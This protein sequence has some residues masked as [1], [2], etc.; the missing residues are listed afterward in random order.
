MTTKQQLPLST[1][2]SVT[3]GEGS[4]SLKEVSKIAQSSILKTQLNGLI[5]NVSQVMRKH[6][7]STAFNNGIVLQSADRHE[8][9]EIRIL[10]LAQLQRLVSGVNATRSFKTEDDYF[11]CVED[12]IEVFPSLKIEEILLCLKEIRQGKHDLYG[13]LCTGAIMKSLHAYEE[14]NTI[15]LREQKHKAQEPYINGMIDWKQLSEALTVD[16]PKRSL[17]ELGGYLNVT[18]QDLKDIEKAKKESK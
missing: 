1:N 6:T 11:D 5:K 8:P 15:P 2:Q 14:S 18:E 17:E 4:L 7:P 3:D 12:I 16:Q 9:A 10:L 13:T